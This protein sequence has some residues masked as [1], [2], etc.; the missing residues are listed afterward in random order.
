M[1]SAKINIH[2]FLR[3]PYKFENHSIEKLF[4]TIIKKKDKDIIF[5]FLICPFESGGFFKRLINCLWAFF[6]QGDVNHIS[7]DINFI[8]LFLNKN[9]TINTFHDCYNLREYTGF[10][11]KL[12]K[13]FWFDIPIKKSKYV[14][15]VSNF[16]KTEIKKFIKTK[17]NINVISNF[18]THNNYKKHKIKRNKILII[19]TTKN[20]NLDRILLA[21]KNLNLELV[22]VGRIN[23]KQIQFMNT[24]NLKYKNYI[25]VS[26]ANLISLYNQSIILL[27]PSLYEGF[28]LTILEAQK[29]GVS[30]ITSNIS[31]MKEIA[32]NS[33]LL[34]NPKNIKDIRNKLIRLYKNPLLRKHLVK[35]GYKNLMRF[36]PEN[37]RK[38]YFLLYK[39]IA[40]SK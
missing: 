17:K 12:F 14:T 23:I 2:I 37:F 21:V 5:K 18:L 16:T 40:K 7:G 6:N 38:K 9:K 3:K 25:D 28:G 26:E 27:F 39:K 31:P 8:S 4:K 1:K 10:K 24:Y 19:G 35:K 22:I 32:G 11:K 29:M 30:V 20:K 33:A 13:L 36:K 15:A 34:V